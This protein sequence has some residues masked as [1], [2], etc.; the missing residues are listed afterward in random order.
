MINQSSYASE[1]QIPILLWKIATYP[2]KRHK[3]IRNFKLQFA[4]TYANFVTLDQTCLKNYIIRK[5]NLLKGCQ[6]LLK[7]EQIASIA[8][9]IQ[10]LDPLKSREY[11]CPAESRTLI[12]LARKPYVA[13]CSIVDRY[14]AICE[15]I[16]LPD[17]DVLMVNLLEREDKFLLTHQHRISLYINFRKSSSIDEMRFNSIYKQLFNFMIDGCKENI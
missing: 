9:Q 1:Y 15:L 16:N 2:H 10:F 14:Q 5:I 11:Y 12:S 8:I 13:I 6:S 3:R 17:K 7:M 4:E